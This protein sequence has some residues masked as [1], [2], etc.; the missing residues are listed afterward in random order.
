[1]LEQYDNKVWHLV[2]IMRVRSFVCPE[3]G[4][5]VFKVSGLSVMGN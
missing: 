5:A 4:H 2:K 3:N 1:M